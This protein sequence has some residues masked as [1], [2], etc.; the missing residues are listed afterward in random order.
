M[1]APG[2]YIEISVER[3][4]EALR[5]VFGVLGRVAGAA[6]A[7]AVLGLLGKALAALPRPEASRDRRDRPGRPRHASEPPIVRPKRELIPKAARYLAL[8]SEA[9][10]SLHPSHLD[11]T[12]PFVKTLVLD[13]SGLAALAR[14]NPRARAHI[15]RAVG[16]IADIV[17]PATALLDPLLAPAA[18]AVGEIVPIDAR[19]AREAA[20]LMVRAQ[21]SLPF[22]AL[23]VACAARGG[24]AGIVTAD[25]SGVGALVRATERDDLYVFG[26]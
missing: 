15:A 1:A 21:L 9:Y 8:L 7:P 17:V 5:A 23:T 18:D 16:T 10:G 2:R 4:R 26:L 19:I 12:L 11:A 24:A 25:P 20:R 13:A 3:E 14:G 6:A 22:D